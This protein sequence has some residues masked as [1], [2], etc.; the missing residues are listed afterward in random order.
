MLAYSLLSKNLGVPPPGAPQANE[1]PPPIEEQRKALG[2]KLVEAI[3]QQEQI[4]RAMVAAKAPETK[5]D[6][7]L[8]FL[9]LLNSRRSHAHASRQ[10]KLLLPDRPP[11]GLAPET[12]R[13]ERERRIENRAKQR[14]EELEN[15]VDTENFNEDDS[16][17][18]KKLGVLLNER[19]HE[20][21]RSASVG[22]LQEIIQLKSLR[23]R[24]KQAKVGTH[25][26]ILPT[27][28]AKF[29]FSLLKASRRSNSWMG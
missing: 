10:Q 6:E 22:R 11:A 1:P 7:H 16:S 26:I 8:P 25:E 14:L 29:I 27:V 2:E 9:D 17:E 12:I 20:T 15:I 28:F 18:P 13:M 4:Y 23:L 5:L 24:Q 3:Y 19:Y 21:V